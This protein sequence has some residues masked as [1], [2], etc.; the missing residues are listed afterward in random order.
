MGKLLFRCMMIVNFFF[1]FKLRRESNSKKVFSIFLNRTYKKQRM[2]AIYFDMHALNRA[3]GLAYTLLGSL[4]FNV[5]PST[6]PTQKRALFVVSRSKT[7]KSHSNHFVAN[8]TTSSVR[9][10]ITFSG[11]FTTVKPLLLTPLIMFSMYSLSNVD[12]L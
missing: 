5:L 4:K 11:T 7:R 8:C 9:I 3:A 2:K 12:I 6:R 10:S 1:T